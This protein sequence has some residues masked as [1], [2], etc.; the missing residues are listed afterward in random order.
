MATKIIDLE[1]SEG[2]NYVTTIAPILQ[3]ERHQCSAFLIIRIIDDGVFICTCKIASS[4]ETKTISYRAFVYDRNFAKNMMNCC[5]AIVDMR[6]YVSVCIL[7]LM[8]QFLYCKKKIEKS[9][10]H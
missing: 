1:K 2:V 9:K 7:D 6:S 8:H 4:D 10:N 5:G 3:M